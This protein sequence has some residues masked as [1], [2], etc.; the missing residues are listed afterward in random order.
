M[1]IF[2][3]KVTHHGPVGTMSWEMIGFGSLRDRKFIILHYNYNTKYN[4]FSWNWL[5]WLKPILLSFYMNFGRICGWLVDMRRKLNNYRQE[6][7]FLQ[8]NLS[9]VTLNSAA[10][11]WISLAFLPG[12]CRMFITGMSSIPQ[13][14]MMD[15]SNNCWMS[16]G[17]VVLKSYVT[18]F[19]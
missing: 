16:D 12:P 5:S 6:S 8:G 2:F 7:G 15:S 1:Q 19:L 9:N 11:L 10:E 14:C 3:L 4:A 17:C 13:Y 18:Q